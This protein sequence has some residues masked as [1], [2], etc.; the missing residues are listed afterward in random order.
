MQSTNNR[1]DYKYYRDINKLV[2]RLQLL[3]ALRITGNTSVSINN[4]FYGIIEE[5]EKYS[6]VFQKNTKC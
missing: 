1:I 2:E 4:E 5:L 6:Y 3:V